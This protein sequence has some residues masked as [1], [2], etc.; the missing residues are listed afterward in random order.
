MV[1]STEE[2]SK[3]SAGNRFFEKV[4]W[5]GQLAEEL[6]ETVIIP[7]YVR[8]ARYPEKNRFVQFSLS[9]DLSRIVREISNHSQASLY[10]FLLSAIAV[11]LKKYTRNSDLIL[12]IPSLQVQPAADAV[13]RVL[14]LRANVS[15]ELTFRELL[16]QVK[17][18]VSNAYIHQTYPIDPLIRL[19][20]LSQTQNRGALFDIVVLLEGLHDPDLVASLKTDL[21]ITFAADGDCISGKIAYSD[22]LFRE[23][24]V[25]AISRCYLNILESVAAH[26][27]IK[28]S[29]IAY[30]NDGD[31]RQ[32]LDAFNDNHRVYP[33]DQTIQALFEKQAKQ[34]PDNIAAVDEQARLSYQAL[35]A[36]ANQLARLL[37]H[38][39][40]ASGEFVGILKGRDIDFLTAI[41]AIHKAGGAYVPVDSSYPLDRIQYMVSNS[42]VRFLLT[43]CESLDSLEHCVSTCPKLQHLISL[44][45]EAKKL[46]K[47]ELGSIKSYNQRDIE[48]FSTDNLEKVSGPAD[49]AYMLYTSGST[50]LPKGAII[51]H[52]GAVNHIYG[53]L[54]AL[55]LHAGFDFLQSAPASS[56]I[57]V[58]QFL[59]PLLTGGKTV[60]VST[61]TVC[62][63]E[64]LFRVIQSEKLTLV[65]LVPIVL[66]GLID[67]LAQLPE[68]DR[69]LPDLHVMMITGEYVPVELVN[70]WLALYPTIRAAN[71][72]G[73][74]EAADDITQLVIEQP[75]P[76]N[77]RTVAIGQPLAN[78]RL[79]VLDEQLQ[80]LPIGAPGEICVSGIGVGSGYWKNPEKTAQSFVPNPFSSAKPSL[81]M[82]RQEWLYRTGD[83]GRWLPDGNLEFLGR[84]DNQVKI[85]GFRIE[86]G[87]IEAHLAQ[88][89]GVKEAVV[90]VREDTPGNKTLVAYVVKSLSAPE[91]QPSSALAAASSRSDVLV[92]QLRLLLK[93]AL[94]EHMVPSAFVVL[95]QLPLTPSGKVDRRALPAPEASRV[96]L[97]SQYVAPSTDLEKEIAAIWQQLLGVQQVGIHDNFFDSGGHSL[98]ITQ[99]FTQ[100]RNTFEVKLALHSLFDLPTIASIAQ[101]IERIRQ[102]PPGTDPEDIPAVDFVAEAIL[103]DRIQ[104]AGVPYNSALTPAAI[105]LTGATG[106]LGAFLLYELLQRSK[107]DIYCLVRSHSPTSAQQKIQDKLASYGIWEESFS[108]RIIPV[109]G[110]LSRPL[111][112]LSQA[113]FHALA[114][115]LDTIYHSGALVNSM[116]PYQ[117][118]K[119][120]NVL[121][122]QEVLRLASLSRVKPVHFVSSTGVIPTGNA[123]AGSILEDASLDGANIP[124]SGYGQSKWVAE[125]LVAIARER[126][127]PVCIYRPGFITGHSQT[128]VCNPGDIIYRMIKGCIQIGHM[129]DLG[130]RLDFNPCDYVSQAI[131]HLSLQPDSLGKVFHLVHPQPLSMGDLFSYA[132]SLGYPMALVDFNQWKSALIAKGSSPDNALY[133]LIPVFAAQE[134]VSLGAN[135]V[136]AADKPVSPKPCGPPIQPFSTQNTVAGL[137]QSAITC[138]PLDETLLGNYFTHL[139]HSGFLEKP[140]AYQ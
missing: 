119:T 15:R 2:K 68:E 9:Q 19:L 131:V 92:P 134:N 3:Q 45:A 64:Q 61:E 107:A 117:T 43:D 74:T 23:D 70:Q 114:G 32:I 78:L 10:L 48:G 97:G 62:S 29:D 21:T 11:L 127:L 58:W 14:P 133:P 118:F 111:L 129:P 103:D 53:Q 122:T 60:I 26:T 5:L 135:G 55:D 72:Y 76:E 22:A 93:E 120:P 52:D 137:A 79:Y 90:I 132:R 67:Y 63:P 35:N 28:L 17:H 80:P 84:I 27:E 140:P 88:T 94:P 25:A 56:D 112:G 95:D 102:L 24:S 104:P 126:G 138:P 34:T 85:R 96:G 91:N 100:L 18:Q 13:N 57:S 46:N 42:G 16:L 110:D 87:E 38:L 121:G 47:S 1:I 30:L 125:N 86:M 73:P 139:V 69:S 113:K 54:D 44:D 124:G 81:P 115:E 33:V 8:P 7:D 99:L 39:G 83:L 71:A 12:G 82:Q 108:A 130:T 36:R 105:L 98:L 20:G 106:F 128:G 89:A 65:E 40:L 50:G 37:Q 31:L 66:K 109:L 77:Q 75:L 101:E 59:G 123:G 136:D 4:Y 51:H 49:P 41:L 6:P 116:S